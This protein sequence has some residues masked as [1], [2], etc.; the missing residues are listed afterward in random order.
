MESV[1]RNYDTI[2][3]RITIDVATQKLKEDKEKES[4]KER[5]QKLKALQNGVEQSVTQVCI[6]PLNGISQFPPLQEP[7]NGKSQFPPL[8]EIKVIQP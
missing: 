3:T 2:Q 4:R 6:E 1:L 5:I 7:L 8:Q